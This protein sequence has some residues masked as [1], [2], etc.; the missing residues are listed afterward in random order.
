MGTGARS[1]QLRLEE[2]GGAFDLTPLRDGVSYYDREDILLC[3]CDRPLILEAIYTQSRRDEGSI[4]CA[5]ADRHVFGSL[6]GQGR[7][8]AMV[9]VLTVRPHVTSEIAVLTDED[10]TFAYTGILRDA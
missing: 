3:R 4:L 1:L 2:G 6:L 8:P 10:V 5:V 7:L 9:N